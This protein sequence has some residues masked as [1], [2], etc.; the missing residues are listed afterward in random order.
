M[1]DE[2]A[3]NDEIYLLLSKARIRGE[4]LYRKACGLTSGDNDGTPGPAE[5]RDLSEISPGATNWE[6]AE[7][8]RQLIEQ[9]E[10]AEAQLD[11]GRA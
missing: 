10:M 5:L 3:T 4:A 11:K 8:L 2:T 9:L 1:S 6:I 7:D